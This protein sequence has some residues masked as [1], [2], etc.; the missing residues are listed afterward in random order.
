MANYTCSLCGTTAHSKCVHQRSV[1]LTNQI[2]PLYSMFMKREVT[3]CDHANSEGFMKVQLVFPV[4]E[5]TSK[6][7]ALEAA[8][9]AIRKM[10]KEDMK[11]WICDHHWEVVK[12]EVCDFGCCKGGDV[13]G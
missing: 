12:D 1:F 4:V 13:H 9:S 3:A 2:A 11:I 5:A 7:Q 6:T 8:L 10:S